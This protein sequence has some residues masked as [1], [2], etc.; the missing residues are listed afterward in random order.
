MANYPTMW[1]AKK[2]QGPT[3]GS[4]TLLYFALLNK[5]KKNKKKKKKKRGVGRIS[6]DVLSTTIEVIT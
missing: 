2:N 1:Y 6:E 5:M 4:P 3:A